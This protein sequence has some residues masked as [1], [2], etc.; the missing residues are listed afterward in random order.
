MEPLPGLSAALEA[1]RRGASHVHV[2]S[3]DEQVISRRIALRDALARASSTGSTTSSGGAAASAAGRISSQ[4]L[5]WPTFAGP[6][7][8]GGE[9]HVRTAR[10]NYNKFVSLIQAEVFDGAASPEEVKAAAHTVYCAVL[11]AQEE[12]HGDAGDK[13]ATAVRR[14]LSSG[15]VAPGITLVSVKQL[16]AAVGELHA[17]RTAHRVTPEIYSSATTTTGA[18]GAAAAAMP[19]AGALRIARSTSA[20]SVSGGLDIV[21]PAGFVPLA[22]A[23][24]PAPSSAAAAPA[25]AAAVA[26]VP[27]PWEPFLGTGNFFSP[28]EQVLRD[29]AAVAASAAAAAAAKAPA[30]GAAAPAAAAAASAA[31]AAP[32]PAAPATGAAPSG[33]IDSVWLYAACAQHIALTSAGSGGASGGAFTPDTLGTALLASFQRYKG[34]TAEE[35][36]RLQMSLFELLGE[37]GLDLMGEWWEVA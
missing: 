10:A 21:L 11:R 8:G 18:A 14:I 33:P 30:T 31:S 27:P 20:A 15:G 25:A 26:A 23:F 17:W 3:I 28:L 29:L 22:S 2:A 37:G 19:A 34:G 7:T 32:R 1:K 4:I 24:Q 35:E 6:Y 13:S 16:Q 12:T 36:A 9:V 5:D